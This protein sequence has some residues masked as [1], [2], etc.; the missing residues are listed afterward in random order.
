MMANKETN[1]DKTNVIKRNKQEP[2]EVEKTHCHFCH[3]QH[4]CV[5]TKI[6]R[7]QFK[8]NRKQPKSVNDI[9]AC[10]FID[11]YLCV[12]CLQYSRVQT[13]IDFLASGVLCNLF[14]QIMDDLRTIFERNDDA[15]K[16]D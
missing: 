14:S 4:A 2:T 1:D 9:A 10:L 5:K 6:P 11:S 3:G 16:D 15:E 12:D 7:T 8:Y 13:V